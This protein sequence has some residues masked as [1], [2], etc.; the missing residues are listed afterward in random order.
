MQ[1]FVRDNNVDQAFAVREKNVK[2]TLRRRRGLGSCAAPRKRPMRLPPK[3]QRTQERDGEE[4]RQAGGRDHPQQGADLTQVTCVASRGLSSA[5]ISTPRR[6]VDPHPAS[7]RAV[8][9]SPPPHWRR[10]ACFGHRVSELALQV[11][12]IRQRCCRGAAIPHHA[13]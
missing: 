13:R 10:L 5:L 11:L 1:V 8:V 2:P 3:A 12:C 7:P 6:C 4:D 9:S